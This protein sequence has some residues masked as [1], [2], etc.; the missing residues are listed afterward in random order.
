MR[1]N[2]RAVKKHLS[3]FIFEVIHGWINGIVGFNW[4]HIRAAGTEAKAFEIFGHE[5]KQ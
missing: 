5:S 4:E 3:L 1:L 2:S